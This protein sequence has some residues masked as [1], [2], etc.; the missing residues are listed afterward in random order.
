MGRVIL[1]TPPTQNRSR[2]LRQL[3]ERSGLD[4]TA[5]ARRLGALIGR[6]QLGPGAIRLWEDDANNSP[7]PPEVIVAAGDMT[8]NPHRADRAPV[9]EPVEFNSEVE[10]LVARLAAAKRV[11]NA[12]VDRLRAHTDSF[13]HIDRQLGTSAVSIDLAAHLDRMT[14]LWTYSA[15]GSVRERL[16]TAVSEAASLAGWQALDQQQLG[17]AWEMHELAKRAAAEGDD[18][19]AQAFAT[20]QQSLVLL[21]AGRIPDAVALVSS[22]KRRLR[23]LPS[24]LVAW[25]HSTEAEVLATAGR[26]DQAQR[27]HRSR[28]TDAGH[29]TRARP[30]LRRA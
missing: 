19:C 15:A 1:L 23:Q 25:L 26:P 20:A 11:D 14:N 7:P 6:P 5:F 27:P 10:D 4:H 17:P 29:A 12:L 2:L 24:R 8:R 21:D 9:S 16:A 18:R 30:P 22:S 3:R 13:R 28:Y